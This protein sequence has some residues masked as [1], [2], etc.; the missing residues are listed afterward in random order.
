MSPNFVNILLYYTV[1]RD[2]IK[3]LVPEEKFW[4]IN[5]LDDHTVE[6]SMKVIDL[7]KT[8]FIDIVHIDEMVEG[9]RLLQ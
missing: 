3:Q 6:N 2:R 7:I 8:H 1:Q 9:F 5:T 4:T